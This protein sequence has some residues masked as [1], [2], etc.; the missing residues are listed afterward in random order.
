MATKA[1]KAIDRRVEAAYYA[2][3]SGVQIDV[4][5]ISKVFA[6][7]RQAIANG[8]DDEALRSAIV[9]FVQTIRKN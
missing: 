5:D 8:A 7:G 3:C 6:A 9:A 1:D 4:M 2:T